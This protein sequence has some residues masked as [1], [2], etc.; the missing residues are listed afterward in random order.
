LSRHHA[1]RVDAPEGVNDDFA[2]D[3]LDGV[4]DDRHGA[5]VKLLK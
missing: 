1:L 4:N 3:G 2:A 5:R